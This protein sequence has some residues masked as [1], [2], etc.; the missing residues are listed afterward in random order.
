MYWKSRL[1]PIL[2][3]TATIFVATGGGSSSPGYSSTDWPQFRGPDGN[4]VAVGTNLPDTWSVS[5][6]VEWKATVPGVGWSS[7]V[8]AGGRVFISTALA[9]NVEEPQPGLPTDDR[10]REILT[11]GRIVQEQHEWRVYCFETTTGKPCGGWANG[12]TSIHTAIPEFSRH[13]K[14]TYANETPVVD[15]NNVYVRIGDLGLWALDVA[16]GAERWE[17][18]TGHPDQDF[19]SWGSSSS[20]VLAGGNVIIAYDAQ[21]GTWLAGFDTTDGTRRWRVARIQ[22]GDIAKIDYRQER[23]TWATP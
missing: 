14:S 9:S 13:A 22:S 12:Y 2:L 5:E 6:N 15:A 8:V 10:G 7:P 11:S 20:P 23:S 1:V 4:G 18:L 3:A 16:D 19:Q 21:D 17:V